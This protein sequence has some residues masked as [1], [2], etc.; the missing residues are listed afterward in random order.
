[1]AACS[2]LDRQSLPQ[3]PF[4]AA[5]PREAS[6]YQ[7]L[8]RE[9]DFLLAICAD[10]H[11]CDRAHF[12]GALVALY[13]NQALAARHFQEV[14]EVAPKSRLAASSQFWLQLLQ[15]PPTFIGR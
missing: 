10:M 14:I 3:T 11:T 4:F 1:M 9:Q 6:R 12:T 2:S 15:T 13:D 8:A 7:L 5:D